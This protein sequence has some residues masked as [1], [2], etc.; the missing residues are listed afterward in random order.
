MNSSIVWVDLEMTGLDIET[1]VI[2]E[3]AC[4]ITDGNLNIIAEA[5]DIVIKVQCPFEFARDFSFIFGI[6]NGLR[7]FCTSS[8]DK[9]DEEKLDNMGEWCQNQ[10]GKSGLT[11]KCRKSQI[12]LVQAENLVC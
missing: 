2:M 8:I 12:S 4:V 7:H 5:D 9:V 11:E 6:G 10:H 1:E 3:M